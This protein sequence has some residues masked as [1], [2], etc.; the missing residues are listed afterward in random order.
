MASN[1]V[2][3]VPVRGEGGDVTG[4]LAIAHT[5]R[6]GVRVPKRAP[7]T[8]REVEIL[9]FAADG[10]GAGDRRA[11]RRQPPH[12]AHPFPEHLREMAR[13]GPRRRGRRSA[14]GL[15]R[16][17]DAANLPCRGREQSRQFVNQVGDG[18]HDPGRAAREALSPRMRGHAAQSRIVSMPLRCR[19]SR[20][21]SMRSPIMVVLPRVRHVKRGPD[22]ERI[23]FPDEVRRKF[24][25]DERCSPV[26]AAVRETSLSPP[27]TSRSR[28]PAPRGRFDS[29]WRTG[30]AGYRASC[31]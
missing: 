3:A 28:S 4:V 21:V 11:A 14:P 5:A 19:R 18:V 6:L 29:T 13:T 8:P 26:G 7:L 16:L 12:G 25:N 31:S 20:R 24:A 30:R 23:R 22:H 15:D 27:P 1:Q 17:E 2:D 9:Q 10:D